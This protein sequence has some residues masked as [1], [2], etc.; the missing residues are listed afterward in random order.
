MSRSRLL[1]V[2]VLAVVPTLAHAACLN[3]FVRRTEGARQVMTLLTGKLTFQE[4]DALSKAIAAKQSPPIEWI[5]DAG[6]TIARQLG[7]MKAVRPMPVACDNR[8]SGSVIMVTFQ[9]ALPPAKK[10]R[11]KLDANTIVDFEE[12]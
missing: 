6:K 12:Q 4:A 9:S 5:D 11:I 3:K 8:T 10:M 7:D 2:F 1:F